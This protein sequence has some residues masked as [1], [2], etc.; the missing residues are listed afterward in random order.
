MFSKNALKNQNT[1]KS[2][3]T[4]K[5]QKHGKFKRKIRKKPR[6]TTNLPP[7][8]LYTHTESCLVNLTK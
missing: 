2:K 4:R 8:T 1:K 3:N 6:T 5:S 7:V